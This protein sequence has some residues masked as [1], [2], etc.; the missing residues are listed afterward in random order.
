MRILDRLEA[1]FGHLAIPGLPTYIA[2]FSALCFILMQIDRDYVSFL[3][4][5]RQRILQGEVWRLFTFFFIPHTGS[6]LPLPG[7]INAAFYVVFLIWMGSGLD[8]AWGAFRTNV[9]CLVGWAAI[10]TGA[11]FFGGF[12]APILWTESMFLAFAWFYGDSQILLYFFPVKVRWMAWFSVAYMTFLCVFGGLGMLVSVLAAL[13]NYFLFFG[14]ANFEMARQE[15]E[16]TARRE[17]FRRELRTS[18]A[19][20]MH[21]CAVCG[22][23]ELTAAHLEFR[24]TADGEEYCTEHLPKRPA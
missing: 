13:T 21:R 18:E 19:D 7:W 5:D 23:T 17:K 20:A 15:Q 6:I 4:F 2:G 3:M 16:H 14:K 8:Q 11:F 24:V 22:R 10:A 12:F 9:Y 1:R